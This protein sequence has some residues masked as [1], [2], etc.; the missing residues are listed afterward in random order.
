MS[1]KFEACHAFTA[2]EEGGWADDRYDPGGATKYGITIH[3]LGRWRKRPVTKDEVRALTK[4]EAK[5]IYQAWYWRPIRGD[6][7]PAGVDLTVY[8]YGVNSGPARSVKSLQRALGVVAD[9]K[10]GDVQTLPALR[11]SDPR[12]IIAAV[13]DERLRFVQ[14]L[15]TWWRFGKG[16]AARIGR[17]RATSLAWAGATV[18]GIRHDANNVSGSADTDERNGKATGAGGAATGAGGSAVDQTAGLETQEL[19][20]ILIVAAIIIGVGVWLF[21]RSRIKR[22]VVSGMSEVI[23]W[24]KGSGQ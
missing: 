16:W 21:M 5:R 11:K 2:R 23:D 15:K 24:V 1:S 17:C 18:D 13:N 4:E 19:V 20:L 6:D 22:D 9:G 3:T 14:S 8:D 10:V 12:K 7:L